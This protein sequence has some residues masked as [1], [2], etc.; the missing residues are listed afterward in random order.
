MTS[1]SGH[2][3]LRT[4]SSTGAATTPRCI[5]LQPI[6][7]G[8]T[9]KIT[10]GDVFRGN[11][12][13]NVPLRRHRYQAGMIVLTLVDGHD[14]LVRPVGVYDGR[15]VWSTNRGMFVESEAA[16][17]VYSNPAGLDEEIEKARSSAEMSEADEAWEA[18]KFED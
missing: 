15:L 8:D 13:E 1:C 9:V 18:A 3:V 12:E 17:E 5:P 7:G 16:G 2:R 4:S 10:L 11:A 6:G 14:V